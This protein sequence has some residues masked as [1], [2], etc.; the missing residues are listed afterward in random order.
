ML[1][2]D[3]GRYVRGIVELAEDH[4]L[5]NNIF[6]FSG[7]WRNLLQALSNYTRLIPIP[8]NFAPSLCFYW[9]SMHQLGRLSF[10]VRGNVSVVALWVTDIVFIDWR[11]DLVIVV[12]K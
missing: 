8:K 12:W 7:P 4:F 2:R 10:M 9:S 5:T 1:R 6:L 11:R 3:K